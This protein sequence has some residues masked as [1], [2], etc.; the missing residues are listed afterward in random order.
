M[1]GEATQGRV[2]R[3]RRPAETDKAA[4]AKTSME[5]E[6]CDSLK[7][8]SR[9][10]LSA[11]GSKRC[12][13]LK[14]RTGIIVGISATGSSFRIVLEGRRQPVTF[15]ASYIEPDAA[16]SAARALEEK[17]NATGCSKLGKLAN[18]LK[19]EKI[20]ERKSGPRTG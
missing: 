9:C 14:S 16:D 18:L 10:R 15:H 17:E 1:D 7:I 13:K 20:D 2:V 3:N 19:T 11:L 5:K 8:G 6:I 12:R 4:S